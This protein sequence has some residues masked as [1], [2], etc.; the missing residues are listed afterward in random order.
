MNGAIP[1]VRGVSDVSAPHTLTNLAD[2]LRRLSPSHRDPERFHADKS[3]I[4]RELRRL[5][6]RIAR[7]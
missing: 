5:A 4:E 2:R 1:D 7:G 6:G 3:E